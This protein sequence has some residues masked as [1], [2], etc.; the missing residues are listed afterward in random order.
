MLDDFI[1]A[2]RELIIAKARERVA[3]RT[4]PRPTEIELKN[5]VPVFL[6]QLVIA[7][8]LAKSTDRVDHGDINE[9]AGKHGLDLLAMGLT[10][11][12]VVHDYGDICQS[13]TELAVQMKAPLSGPEFQT[14]NL[15][16]DD[17]IAEAVTEYAR[18]RERTI[19]EEGTE[20]LGM[21]AHEQRNLL[22]SAMLAFESI[23]TGRVPSNG[24]TGVLLGRSLA[25]LRN[26]IDRS[27]VDVRIDAGLQRMER[28]SVAE[29]LEDVEVGAT[30]QAQSRDLHFS[31]KTVD[32]H[33]MVNA[34]RQILAGAISNLLQNAFKFT[35]KAGS[36]SLVVRAT[37]SRV[38][39][40]IE[41]ECGGLPE[42][43]AE[44]LFRPYA[45]RGSDR[46]GVGLGLAI[47]MKA[48]KA[49]DGDL[50]VRDLPGKGC[51]FTMDLPR[52]APVAS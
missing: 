8:R 45:Q 40:E 42:G 33:V 32:R 11:A 3:S 7:L 48:A 15:C 26:L 17:A 29:F 46:S 28:F 6:D 19:S 18:R 10:I 47:C 14:L 38:F 4:C 9:S 35:K 16:L 12:Q 1:I 51:V 31:V 25:G 50:R 37:E 49:N 41:D 52:S 43:K 13:I 24:S 39:F 20:R 44:T 2:N 36:V 5:G 34:D 22:N 21:L 30:L 23:K 27:L